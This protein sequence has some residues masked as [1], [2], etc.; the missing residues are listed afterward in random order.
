MNPNDVQRA[1][2]G[3]EAALVRLLD[4]AAPA[5]LRELSRQIDARHRAVVDAEDI[6]QVTCVEAFLHVRTFKPGGP[7]SFFGWL[8][9]IAENNLSDAVR[10]LERDKRPPPGRR[11]EALVG[12]ESYSYEALIDR[13]AITTSTP[14]RAA[15][16]HEIRAGVDAALR[17]LPPDYERALRLY[18]LEGLSGQEVADR[19]GRR[20]GAVRVLLARAR[21]RL[22]E[23]L[24]ADA[25]FASR[26]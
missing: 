4:E 17:Q 23:I 15:A 1:V 25:Q 11:I 26:V 6:V 2:E 10:E 7:G 12:D 14:S 24:S 22:A 16:R 21:Q 5:L 19:M 8:R 3:D 13:L 20:H 9:R 18:E